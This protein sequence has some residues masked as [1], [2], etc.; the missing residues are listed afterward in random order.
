M[1]TLHRLVKEL[2]D[3]LLSGPTDTKD[4]GHAYLS[5]DPAL[6]PTEYLKLLRTHELIES[7]MEEDDNTIRLIDY[8]K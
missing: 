8:G 4:G 3:R 5:I 1:W 2:V 6:I 7:Y